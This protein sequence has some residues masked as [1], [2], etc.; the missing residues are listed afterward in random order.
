RNIEADREVFDGL[1]DAYGRSEN[2]ARQILALE[3]HGQTL[4][5]LALLREAGRLQVDTD[6]VGLLQN[7]RGL[8]E[9]QIVRGPARAFI[10]EEVTREQDDQRRNGAEADR[11]APQMIA[12]N[13]GIE[14]QDHETAARCRDVPHDLPGADAR[15]L[16][17]LVDD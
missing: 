6:V 3:E 12:E 8:I 13:A 10:G 4:L 1:R 9:R 16:R 7:L 5:R 14:R 11:E 17:L 2:G 15:G